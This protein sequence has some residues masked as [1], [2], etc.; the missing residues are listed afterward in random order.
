MNTQS[1][2]WGNTLEYI[3]TSSFIFCLSF[4]PSEPHLTQYLVS[5]KG[6]TEQQVNDDVYPCFTYSSFVILLLVAGS[7]CIQFG[8][9][10]GLVRCSWQLSDQ[11][12]IL[13]G[14]TG[15]VITRFLLLFG[16]GL[17]QMQLMQVTFSFGTITEVVFYAYI[18]K[19][20]PAEESQSLTAVAQA[21]F[22]AAHVVSGFL[23][24]V[25][26]S[27][28][29]LSGLMWISALFVC[30]AACI[31]CTFRHVDHSEAM[32]P[33]NCRPL[34]AIRAVYSARVFWMTALWWTLNYSVYSI[35]FSYEP[36]LYAEYLGKDGPDLNGSI[37]AVALLV[38]AAA[39]LVLSCRCVELVVSK[40]PLLTFAGLSEVMAAMTAFMGWGP[41]SKLGVA[42]A[43]TGFFAAWSFGNVLFYGETRRVVDSFAETFVQDAEE[44]DRRLQR[45][46]S[47]PIVLQ[48]ISLLCIL[49][50]T[51]GTCFSGF[52]T[53]VL[54]TWQ[55]LDIASALKGMSL[56]QAAV[57][58]AMVLFAMLQAVRSPVT[59]LQRV[60]PCN[61]GVQSQ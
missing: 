19:V 41:R 35:V 29:G 2:C 59:S 26:L 53:A 21:A 38:G 61:D 57:G 8:L 56:A 58:G 3:R 18:L 40:A 60:P 37:S 12:L 11:L 5:V 43:F 52:L 20:V 55:D 36:S 32:Q 31:A 45:Q 22:L 17:R 47:H 46:A 13:F 4:K 14:C 27:G 6:L 54:F 51:L 49:N 9:C 28:V 7:K 42:S 34:L 39:A 48:L 16:T 44:Y 10:S 33:C 30:M 50:S 25:L 24:D 15:R 1:R 23:G